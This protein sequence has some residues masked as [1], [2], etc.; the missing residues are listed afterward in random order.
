MRIVPFLAR[1]TMKRR[2]AGN[3]GLDMRTVAVE[4]L[5]NTGK[6]KTFRFKSEV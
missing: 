4:C 2:L 3:G 1:L 5:V 6:T